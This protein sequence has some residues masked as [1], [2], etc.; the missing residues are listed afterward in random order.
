VYVSKFVKTIELHNFNNEVYKDLLT[1]ITRVVPRN[2][3]PFY[4]DG[5]FLFSF[6]MNY[7]YNLS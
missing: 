2:V 7:C 1:L 5:R 4:E 3:R 6:L